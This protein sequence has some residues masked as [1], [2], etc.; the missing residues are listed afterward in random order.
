MKLTFLGT[1]AAEGI[2]SPFCDCPGCEYARAHGGRNVRR[3][4]SVLV[5]DDMLIDF[6]PDIFPS[7]AALGLSL[8]G[9]KHLL[10]THSH[11]DHFNVDHL[12]MRS[13]PFRLSTEL[14]E[15][16]MIAGPSV[17]S[18]WSELGGSDQGAGIRR[19]IILPRQS[20]ELP[21]YSIASL[22]ACHHLQIGDAMNYIIDDGTVKLL[23]ASDSGYYDEP[24]WK[25]LQNHY[26]DAVILEG[27]IW[28]RPAGREHLNEGDF[29]RMKDRLRSIGAITDET[30]VIATHFSHQ[31]VDS[32]ENL[33]KSVAWHGARCAYDG[34]TVEIVPVKK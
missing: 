26:F 14:P 3:R 31:S 13:R 34:M 32:H 4:Q 8:C 27:T 28:N 25:E 2:P 5:N 18:K 17:W 9:L 10:V 33:E 22:A 12:K 7:C 11:A 19:R 21:E 6:G 16:T 15:M 30:L 23:Y 20:L 1:G 24:V 29:V